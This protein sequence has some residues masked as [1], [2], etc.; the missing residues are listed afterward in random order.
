MCGSFQTNQEILKPTTEKLKPTPVFFDSLK[1]VKVHTIIKRMCFFS[2]SETCFF[3]D[4]SESQK[5]AS[6]FASY[7]GSSASTRRKRCEKSMW[8]NPWKWTI[9][10]KNER[11]LLTKQHGF[12]G[13]PIYVSF[14]EGSRWLYILLFYESKDSCHFSNKDE[15]R[16]NKN[17]V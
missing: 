10:P 2:Q 16:A 11:I 6:R 12:Q 1:K 15:K 4:L 17:P 8:V 14:R 7:L 13:L 9:R 5:P 3:F